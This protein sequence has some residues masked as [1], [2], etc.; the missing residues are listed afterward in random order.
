MDN[1][2]QVQALVLAAGFGKRLGELTKKTPKPLLPFF[3]QPTLYHILDKIKSLKITATWVNSHYLWEK[4]QTSLQNYLHLQTSLSVEKDSLLGTGGCIKNLPLTKKNLLVIN[5]DIVFDFYLQR[6]L[7]LH[8]NKQHFATM[9][10]RPHTPNHTPLWCENGL[11]KGIGHTPPPGF[12]GE[13]KSFACVQ[14]LSQEFIQQ[15]PESSPHCIISDYR[16]F[17]KKG[18]QINYLEEDSFWYDLGSPQNYLQAHLDAIK[19]LSSSNLSKFFQNLK[20]NFNFVTTATSIQENSCYLEQNTFSCKRTIGENT[21]ITHNCKISENV[22]I[23]NSLLLPGSIVP[24][25]VNIDN[26]I[27]HSL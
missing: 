3:Y 16:Y 5:A 25:G 11:V 18:Y 21:I 1:N 9:I 27:I 17:I 23:K 26:Q 2:S 6:L 14:L 12:C 22:K 24:Y 7:D 19:K 20:N 4:I 8:L 13:K 10:V 15:I